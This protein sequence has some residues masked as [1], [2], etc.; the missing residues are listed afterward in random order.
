MAFTNC[1][2]LF[3][4]IAPWNVIS[5]N[6]RVQEHATAD[7]IRRG[8]ASNITDYRVYIL[9]KNVL[10][11]SSAPWNASRSM[12]NVVDTANQY[13]GQEGAGSGVRNNII[14]T[15][16]R[17]SA[18]SAF[19]MRRLDIGFRFVEFTGQTDDFETFL[20]EGFSQV[21]SR[22]MQNV[23]PNSRVGI[24]ISVPLNGNSEAIGLS[25]RPATQISAQLLHDLLFTVAQSNSTFSI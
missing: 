13:T 25:F 18:S 5:R 4:F 16:T 1:N 21:L 24:K 10:T 22:V 9:I 3:Y 7:A 19:Y 11:Y 15:G 2:I 8:M 20:L 14:Y 23:R 17:E 6:I 12:Q